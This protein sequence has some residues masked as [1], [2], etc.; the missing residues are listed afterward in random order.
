MAKLTKADAAQ[1]QA[2]LELV[3]RGTGH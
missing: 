1:T 3:R 2:L